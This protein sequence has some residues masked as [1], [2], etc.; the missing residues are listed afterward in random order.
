M[1]TYSKNDVS[2]RGGNPAVNVKVYGSPY[3]VSLPLDLGSSYPTGQPELIEHHTTDAGFT[4]KWLE[5]HVSDLDWT[6]EA[7]CQ[8]GWEM[9]ETEAAEIFGPNITLQQE[10][11]SG[12]W[13]VVEGLADIEEW[14]AIALGKWRRFEKCANAIVNDIPRSMVWLAW[15]NVF[16]PEQEAAREL[17]IALEEATTLGTSAF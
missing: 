5:A 6:F 9:L 1:R 8:D 7:A 4:R 15:A 2:L 12:G 16:E 17:E 3:D 10:G 13:C 14:D 11:R